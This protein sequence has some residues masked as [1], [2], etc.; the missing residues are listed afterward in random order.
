MHA[1]RGA[2][3]QLLSTFRPLF[4]FPIDP[5]LLSPQINFKL[6]IPPEYPSVAPGVEMTRESG[7]LLQGHPNVFPGYGPHGTTYICLDMLK[8]NAARWR[9]WSAAYTLRVVLEQ[10]GGFLLE[11]ETIEQE[12]G[13]AVTRRDDDG[14]GQQRPQPML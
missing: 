11:D 6:I 14:A 8:P 5:P 13:S 1:V 2:G 12:Y 3:R 4:T 10:L 9:G 7:L